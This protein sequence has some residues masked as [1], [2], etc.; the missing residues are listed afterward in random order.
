MSCLMRRALSCMC[1]LMTN[2]APV[3]SCSCPAMHAYLLIP[4]HLSSFQAYRWNPPPWNV[5]SI[6]PSWFSV[7][8]ASDCCS[9]QPLSAPFQEFIS[10]AAYMYIYI[11]QT[12]EAYT[13]LCSYMCRHPMKL[14]PL[15]PPPPYP[16]QVVYT[17]VS[18]LAHWK[19]HFWKG[20][21][22]VMYMYMYDCTFRS[23]HSKVYPS[24]ANPSPPLTPSH[25]TP[26]LH[27]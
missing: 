14:S 18:H 15:P 21:V 16:L 26:S 19:R 7:S 5:Y 12:H 22:H 23:L 10:L 2:V 27:P 6:P 11:R 8:R 17:A 9:L 3:K 25:F 20:T 24:P 4:C 13:H 1:R